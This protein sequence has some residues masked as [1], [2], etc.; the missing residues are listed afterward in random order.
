MREIISHNEIKYIKRRIAPYIRVIV[1]KFP[2]VVITGA[3]QVGKSTLVNNEFQDFT[4]LTMDDFA[5]REKA[6]LVTWNYETL[7]SQSRP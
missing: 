7:D 2:V 3:R 6:C 1:E 5:L 4:Y